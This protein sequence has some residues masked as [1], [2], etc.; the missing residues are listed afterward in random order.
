LLQAF[1]VHLVDAFTPLS[2]ESVDYFIV[3][4]F[5]TAGATD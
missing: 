1:S 4:Q 5:S 3:M 2:I